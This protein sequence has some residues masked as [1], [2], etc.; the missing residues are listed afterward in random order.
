MGNLNKKAFTLY[1]IVISFLVG[2]V[3]LFKVLPISKYSTLINPLFWI[4]MAILSYLFT[5]DE[6][7]PRMRSK[8][9]IVQSLIIIMIL[10]AMGYFSLGLFFGYEKSPY[11]H[12]FIAIA[13]NFWSFVLIIVFQEISRFHMLKIT[14]KKIGWYGLVTLFFIIADIDFWSFSSNFTSNAEFFKYVSQLLLP[15]IVSNCLFTYLCV[16]SGYVPSTLYRGIIELM[17]ILLPIFPSINWLIKSMIDI[18]LVIIVALYVNYVS[19]RASRT[20][21]RR[22]LKKESV[23]SYIPFVIVLV[24]MVC[25]IGG[26][27]KYQPI[28]V[29]SNSMYPTFSRGDAIVIKKLDE[30]DKLKLKKDDVIYFGKDNNLVIHRIISITTNEHG[31]LEIVTKGDNNNTQDGWIVTN[32][33]ILG[34]VK[35]MVPY[36]GYPSVFVNDL[37]KK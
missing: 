8:Y 14:P 33:E 36:I 30:N 25:F 6:A 23:A 4:F 24:V 18:I 9:D 3:F 16:S 34:K 31:K 15:L 1:L 19:A 7:P 26:T 20:L 27:F 5:K 21:N 32:E 13:K 22:D 29:L 12:S 11:A 2:R 35:L 37:L 17:T 28:A 10:Y